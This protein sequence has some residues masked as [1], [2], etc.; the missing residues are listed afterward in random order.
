MKK[1][2]ETTL[3]ELLAFFCADIDIFLLQDESQKNDLDKLYSKEEI[4]EQLHK[5]ME[6]FTSVFPVH[7][8]VLDVP[9]FPALTRIALLESGFSKSELDS[10]ENQIESEKNKQNN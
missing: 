3:R 5:T 8:M 4:R 9:L 1:Q 2:N 6:K 10:I 7:P